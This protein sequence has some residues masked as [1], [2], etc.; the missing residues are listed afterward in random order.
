MRFSTYIHCNSKFI[1]HQGLFIKIYGFLKNIIEN[2]LT[3]NLYMHMKLNFVHW[4]LGISPLGTRHFPAAP[5]QI[6]C[7]VFPHY[8]A[9]PR[10]GVGY[11]TFLLKKTNSKRTKQDR[12][13]CKVSNK[14]SNKS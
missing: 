7:S 4:T 13:M 12:E 14:I 1:F 10:R 8:T 3:Q 9:A 5:V 2:P 11:F 6:S